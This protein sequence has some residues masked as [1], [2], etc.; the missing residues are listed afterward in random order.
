MQ[1]FRWLAVIVGVW[2]VVISHAY[3]GTYWATGFWFCVTLY[4]AGNALDHGRI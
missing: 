2:L 1:L 4:N 3:F